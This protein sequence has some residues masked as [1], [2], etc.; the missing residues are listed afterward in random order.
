MPGRILALDYGTKRIGVALSDEL[1]WTAQPL[2]TFERRTLDRDVV[3][4]AALV[5]SHSVERVVL[6][7][8]LQLDGREGPAVRAMREFTDKLEA[9]LPVPVVLWDER[10]TTKAAEELLIAADVSR[11]K[12]K[13]IVDRIAAAILLRSYLEAQDQVSAQ[14]A[15]GKLAE[16]A[17]EECKELPPDDQPYDAASDPHRIDRHRRARRRGRVSDD[18]VG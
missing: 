12:R 11:K 15:G 10:M 1:G 9:S 18:S 8:P 17:L 2:E 5:E 13:G 6:G 3:H 16:E 7:L 14:S 4:I